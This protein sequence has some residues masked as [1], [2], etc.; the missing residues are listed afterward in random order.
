MAVAVTEP[1]DIVV[2]T[3]VRRV[4]L[5]PG[6]SQEIPITITRAEKY[7]TG[8]VTLWADLRFRNTVFGSTLPPGVTLD[9]RTSKVALNGS[10]TAGKV[11]L[12]AATDAK[13][14]DAVQTTV[15]GLVAVEFSV[16]VPYCTSPIELTV[17]SSEK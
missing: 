12:T 9:A 15:I 6:Q 8:P 1:S 5:R 2:D 17:L 7:K 13:P 10:E 11:T 3:P 16:F 14:I 4:V